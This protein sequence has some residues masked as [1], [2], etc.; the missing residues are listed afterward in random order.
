ML[1]GRCL[2]DWPP[3]KALATG[4]LC[5]SLTDYISNV[6]SQ[7]IAGGIKCVLYSLLGGD[8]WKFASI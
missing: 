3:K 5:A 1:D 8:H 6:L 2:C 4:F 7:F